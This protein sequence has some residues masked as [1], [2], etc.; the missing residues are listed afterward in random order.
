MKT[1]ESM[2]PRLGRA[3]IE[4]RK[5]LRLPALDLVERVLAQGDRCVEDLED[6]LRVTEPNEEGNKGPENAMKG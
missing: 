1:K 5:A 6:I 4:T 2:L 3:V